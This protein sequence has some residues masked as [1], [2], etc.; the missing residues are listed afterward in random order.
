MPQRRPRDSQERPRD[1]QER[2]KDVQDVSK[3]RP[4]P[5]KIEPGGPQGA[6]GMRPSQNFL[7]ERPNIDFCSFLASRD[8][9]PR[10]VSYCFFQYKMRVGPIM[11][12]GR[13]GS[14]NLRKNSVWGFKTCP[15]A[16][17]NRTWSVTTRDENDQDE[18]QARRNAQD[19]PKMR[20][21]S[22]QERKLV[23]RLDGSRIFTS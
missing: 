15:R 16:L 12:C 7:L 22:A 3:R 6:S 10:C 8:E 9:R 18:Q 2:P 21:K 14:K 4:E 17:Q 11:H 13:I 19:A 5:S 1:A 23:F 20:K